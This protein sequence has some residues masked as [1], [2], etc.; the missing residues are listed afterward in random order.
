[1]LETSCVLK[2]LV[3]SMTTQV[4]CAYNP[5]QYFSVHKYFI[6]WLIYICVN[7]RRFLSLHTVCDLVTLTTMRGPVVVH[8]PWT[9]GE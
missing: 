1:M 8:I 9:T 3:C 5:P 6:I 7:H 2:H 4:E